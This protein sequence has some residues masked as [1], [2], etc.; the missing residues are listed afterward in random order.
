MQLG[1]FDLDNRYAQLS[2]LND[3]LEELNRIIDWNL[4][5]DLLAETTTKPRKSEAG[6]KP[7]DRVM[8]FKMLV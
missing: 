4:F 7:F 2:K 1:F 6:R 3:P 5:A 8:L